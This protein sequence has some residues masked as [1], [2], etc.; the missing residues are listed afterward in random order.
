[1]DVAA[2]L[3]GVF[4]PLCTPFAP[5]EDVD[6]G[7]LRFNVSRYAGSGLLGYLALGSNGENRS[8][9]EDE[10]LRVLDV[11]VRHKGPGQVVMAGASYDAQRDT[12]RFLDA[13]ADLGADFGLVLSPGYFRRQMT[14]DVLFR[15]FSS[16]ADSTPI[17][18]LLYNAPG[19][20]GVTLSPAL[21]ARLAAH[22]NIVGMKDSA[23]D[24]I[25][26]FLGLESPTFHVLAGS[27]NFLFP[28]MMGGA[29]GG[30]VSLANAFP[31]LALDLFAA[32]R[33]R[34][35]R[36]GIPLQARVTRINRAISGT[37]GVPGVKAAMNLAGFVGGLPRRPLLPLDDTQL[38]ALRVRLADEALLS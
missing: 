4:A 23:T 18:L 26:N 29:P 33:E 25:E 2:N 34:D 37:Y 30:T 14:D 3:A 1:M 17:P 22:P 19:F 35:E 24:G 15:Y 38:A 20:C 10:R 6:Y 9:D 7:A 36:S 27:A 13:A 31:G 16:L 5:N 8:L 12:E 28:A 32:G 21:V 11:I